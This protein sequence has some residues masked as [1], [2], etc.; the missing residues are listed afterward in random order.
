VPPIATPS[1]PAP[2]PSPA[3]RALLIGAVAV[4]L[5]AVAAGGAMLGA[6]WHERSR[7][8]VAA[9]GQPVTP[10]PNAAAH[11]DTAPRA[12]TTPPAKAATGVE[13]I[14]DVNDL[15][16]AAPPKRSVALAAPRPPRATAPAAT[17]ARASE[18]AQAEDPEPESPA[19][20]A[21]AS[22]AAAAAPAE[23]ASAAPTVPELDVPSAPPP[24]PDPLIQAVKQ[25][26]TEDRR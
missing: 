21:S 8:P 24:P 18:P 23:S 5:V 11:P 1:I 16:R 10:P 14:T 3:K 15:P 12:A 2:R 13:P 20:R 22:A 25:S 9:A 6:G 17:A 7:V 26:I 19:P 4:L